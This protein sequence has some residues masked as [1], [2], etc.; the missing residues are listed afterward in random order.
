LPA[1]LLDT[2][3]LAKLYHLESGSEF[4]E[5]LLARPNLRCIVSR[6]SLVEI[7]SVFVKKVLTGELDHAG[8]LM[9]RRRLQADIS[10]S[11]IEIGSPIDNRH[12][13]SA[14]QLLI[15]YGATHGLRTLDSIQLEI[16]LEL[17]KLGEISAFVTADRRLKQI[18]DASGC[19]ALDPSS[20]SITF[21]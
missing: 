18:S 7:E 17:H 3:A 13:R 21:R 19:P 1:Y 9:S 12:Y 8:L 10:H 5:I 15:A 6:L 2:S 20:N 4:M 16:A 11:R 14:R